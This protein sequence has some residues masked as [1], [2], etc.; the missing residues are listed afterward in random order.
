MSNRLSSNGGNGSKGR[1]DVNWKN[2]YRDG[3]SAWLSLILIIILIMSSIGYLFYTGHFTDIRLEQTRLERVKILRFE[4]EFRPRVIIYG[5]ITNYIGMSIDLPYTCKVDRKY[6]N[7]EIEIEV[8]TK[9]RKYNQ[10]YYHEYPGLSM[11]CMK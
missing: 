7:K 9:F 1:L 2:L 4:E 3:R 8:V 11:L 10:S 6:T 5:A